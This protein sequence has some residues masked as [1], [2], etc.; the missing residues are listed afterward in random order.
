MSIRVSLATCTAPSDL[1]YDGN[2]AEREI[3]QIL[4]ISRAR[5][6]QALVGAGIERRT[7]RR[8]CPVDAATL[9][10]LYAEPGA[11]GANL[12]RRFGVAPATAARWLA[13]A[14]LLPLDPS[15]DHAKL[16]EL[17]VEGGLTI[18]EVAEKLGATHARVQQGL[19]AAGIPARSNRAR[20]PRGNRT[21]VTDRRLTGLY[22]R[23]G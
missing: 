3:A 23:R 7:T 4:S 5:V 18:K 2:G 22:V 13:D 19:A 8:A 10:R 9:A 11:N 15:V 14:A 6:A 12:P 17:Y 20:R 16:A 1:N 21:R